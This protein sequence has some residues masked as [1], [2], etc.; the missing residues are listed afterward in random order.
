MGNIDRT[1]ITNY[2]D[3]L[4]KDSNGLG[5]RKENNLKKLSGLR[6]DV[7]HHINTTKL[8]HIKYTHY[9]ITSVDKLESSY[10]DGFEKY[11][12]FVCRL[13][14]LSEKDT[15]IS[16]IMDY[17][18]SNYKEVHQKILK[19]IEAS[20]IEGKPESLLNLVKFW[21]LIRKYPNT[22]IYIEPTTQLWS[23]IYKTPQKGTLSLIVDDNGEIRFSFVK[24]NE[25]LS[26]FTGRARIS[27]K[28]RDYKHICLLFEMM[29][30]D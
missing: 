29:S 8:S 6:E 3:I 11:K 5:G 27:K 14:A 15:H 28:I 17:L 18:S 7:C 1:I 12:E 21:P 4:P 2:F 23:M 25:G 26:K 16:K 20:S 10:D 30:L 13:S 9:P 19:A 22:Y 24:R